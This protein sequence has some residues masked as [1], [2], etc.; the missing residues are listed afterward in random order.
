MRESVFELL[1]RLETLLQRG[2]GVP[3]TDKRVVDER[4]AIGVLEMIRAVLPAQLR[5]AAARADEA[6]RVLRAAQDDARRIVLEAQATA[7][8]LV[9][10]H[11]LLA[12]AARRGDDLLARAERDAQ[13]V[14]E[15]ADHYAAGVLAELEESV[16]RVLD[17]IRRGRE[18]LKGS[19]GSAYN[20]QSGERR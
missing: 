15:G 19:A 7:R 17:A 20:E 11:A 6:E 10:D 12:E 9:E 4:E 5:D 13:A 1:T 18:M 16:R 14:R 2:A 3:L 8:R